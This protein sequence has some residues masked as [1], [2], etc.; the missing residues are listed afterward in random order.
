VFWT[1]A[2]RLRDD[3]LAAG[4]PPARGG[5]GGVVPLRYPQARPTER[6]LVGVA[7]R[8][9]AVLGVD[10]PRHAVRWAAQRVERRLDGEPG[11]HRIGADGTLRREQPVAGGE[12]VLIL[13]HGTASS[14]RNAFSRL[15]A[16]PGQDSPWRQL[17]GRYGGRVFGFEHRTLT[18]S[19]LDN[20]LALLEAL[21]KAGAPPLHLVSH[22]RGG[23]IGE[24]L[25]FGGRSP[26]FPEELLAAARVD[27]DE[28]AKLERLDGLLGRLRPIER[29]VRVACP[30]R[31]TTLAS[32]RLDVYFSILVQLLEATHP[33]AGA[34]G[35]LLAAVVKERTQPDSLP[36]LA[37]QMPTSSLIR[38]LH[39]APPLDSDLTVIA[40]DADG[41][42]EGLAD[43]FF[44]CDNDLVVDTGSMYGGA[45]R[46]RSR[47]Y[48]AK[49][50]EVHHC[51]YFGRAE[52]VAKMV[53]GL[54][55]GEDEDAGCS[56]ARAVAT[57][58]V[59]RGAACAAAEATDRPAVVLVPGAMGSHLAVVGEEGRERVWLDLGSLMRGGFDGLADPSDARRTVVADGLL[60]PG[61]GL[62]AAF[63]RRS[64]HH[65][66]PYAY[67][68]RR[69]LEEAAAGLAELLDERLEK[70][71]RPV[72]IVAHSSGG[73]VARMLIATEPES[74]A[75]TVARGGRLVQLGTPHR[76]TFAVPS[77]LC[78]DDAL[79][80]KLAL[81][82][83]ERG[84]HGWRRAFARFPG[85]VALAPQTAD[86]RF[87]ERRAWRELRRR[88]RPGAPDDDASLPADE[89]LAAARE[90]IETLT[91]VDLSRHPVA[92]VAGHAERTPALLPDGVVGETRRG[93]G[94]VSWEEGIPE[95][96]PTW[97][98]DAPHG[99]LL[100]HPPAFDGL[101]ELVVDG[102]TRRLSRSEPAARRRRSRPATAAPAPGS[103]FPG[104]AE[105]AAS[106]FPSEGSLAAA[107]LGD[108]ERSPI[109]RTA[110]EAPP[111]EVCV[112]HGDLAYTEHP[113]MVGHYVG[114]PLLSAEAALDRRLDGALSARNL[115]G[116]YPGEIPSH[117]VIL[118][119]GADDGGP[120]GALVVGLGEVGTLTAGGLTRT[121]EEA[122]VRYGQTWRE[123]PE[124]GDG[125]GD[126][127][128]GSLG[129]SSLLIGS[130]TA[131]LPIEQSIAS[132]LLG[133]RL[134]NQRLR[135]LAAGACS[136][137]AVERLELIEI[138]EDR[139]LQALHVLRAMSGEV[140]GELVV[141]PDLV[142]ADGG[143]RR[144]SPI[145]PGGWWLPVT[146]CA[147]EEGEDVLEVVADERRARVKPEKVQLQPELI[148]RLLEHPIET[149]SPAHRRVAE[150][151]FELLL[152]LPFKE[153]VAERHKMLLVVDETAA[154][155]P[156][157][158]LVDR[159]A[160]SGRPVGA[161][162]GLVRQLRLDRVRHD[163]CHPERRA[164]LVIG[165]PPSSLPGLPGAR[166]E[167]VRVADL[168][169]RRG[170][171]VERQ[172]RGDDESEK[173]PGKSEID[174]A[175]I[176]AET[177]T[178]DPRILHLA[179]HG[180]Y[181]PDHPT[182]TGMVIGCDGDEES[183]TYVLLS[184]AEIAQMRLVPELVFVNCC[185][186]G[187]IESTPPHL[188]AANLATELI[189]SGVRA[190]V[191][192]GWSVDDAAAALFAE[193]FY[194]RLLAGRTFGDAVYEARKQ[195]YEAHPDSNTWAAYQCYG[196]PGFRLPDSA[197]REE[198]EAAPTIDP[199]DP[200]EVAA[201]LHNLHA[202]AKHERASDQTAALA[203]EL[204][205]IE[206]LLRARGW[207]G[208][209]EMHVG[210]ARAWAEIGELDRGILHYETARSIPSAAVSVGD[211][212]QLANLRARRAAERA[213]EAEDAESRARAQEEIR[214]SIAELET[215][216]R[217]AESKER[218]ALLG[219]AHRRLAQVLALGSDDE[220]ALRDALERTA[221][222]YG[223]AAAQAPDDPYPLINALFAVVVLGGPWDPPPRGKLRGLPLA[224]R[225]T[226]RRELH[227]LLDRL[228]TAPRRKFW[229]HCYAADTALL[230][231]LH[232]DRLAADLQRLTASYRDLFRGYGSPREHASVI[233]HLSFLVRQLRRRGVD[234]AVVA[235]RADGIAAML[236]AV[237][238]G[239][240][241]V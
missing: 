25:C 206:D 174:P 23:L 46:R 170:W 98:L 2:D 201:D 141:S 120:Q 39:A 37:A 220:P 80:R 171:T 158:L 33:I 72:R 32:G 215:L 88:L 133:V 145:E 50:R 67:D 230:E 51:R 100:D 10:L 190:V 241:S 187:R 207:Q 194:D 205:R 89:L 238:G 202:R 70:S 212:E 223:D 186:L 157:E 175:S 160:K 221:K 75:R 105:L 173:G 107:A 137:V 126:H 127:G 132:I 104:E 218:S 114:D 5:G 61:D 142:R 101:L 65:V 117:E 222:H 123:R 239:G 166:D 12:P 198:R 172:I 181:D 87:F 1:R 131:G 27:D 11:L 109:E 60:D 90:S 216:G 62:F 219:S 199:V 44:R 20:A 234:D 144:A 14:T 66:L 164:A 47:G 180:L 214:H 54:L 26:A 149:A 103:P 29:F 153:R 224:R 179:G 189:A 229:D 40:G 63:L 151:L 106:V 74:W 34:V 22:S 4:N 237:R 195:T 176:A 110:A 83:P 119:R 228:A 81:V 30:A 68:W 15:I 152:P 146:I 79:V 13:L 78:G 240:G 163:V 57:P 197:G 49:G 56:T 124:N 203:R 213:A 135:Q 184:A 95:G 9:L 130:G 161:D 97:Y 92:Y 226:F 53:D 77:L 204:E 76:G 6:G 217:L 69:P 192:A 210:L 7:I 121:V 59:R 159:L 3:L 139:A 85:L 108:E 21:P 115:L 165:D 118:R 35:E 129:L 102:A 91:G 169:A 235:G 154:R 232:E 71:G 185:S 19:P 191:A 225:E 227:D 116:L 155:Y 208:R 24:L 122:V 167:A 196:D 148:A 86:G 94:R 138:Y 55:R 168:L 38:A 162:A 31:G 236:A 183:P 96:V 84:E 48:L 134:A 43:L 150:A 156:W 8:A 58:V 128:G 99:R 28:R 136:P 178:A 231:A 125:G 36:G 182:H 233:D 200:A 143:H 177:M 45:P 16:A 41:P 211:L 193:T 93:D 64:G 17:H 73:L 42:L 111:C 140:F 52:T 209:A 82:D 113:V 147:A 188:L 18:E 112:V